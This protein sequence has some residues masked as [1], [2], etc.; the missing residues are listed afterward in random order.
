VFVPDNQSFADVFGTS[1][2]SVGGRPVETGQTFETKNLTV[3]SVGNSLFDWEFPDGYGIL[4]EDGRPAALG[5]AV[6]DI[7]VLSTPS[8]SV[9]GAEANPLVSMDSEALLTDETVRTLLRDVGISDADEVRWIEGPQRLSQEGYLAFDDEIAA[10]APE[11]FASPEPTIL[12]EATTIETYAGV[13]S[14][15]RGPWAVGVHVARATPDDHVSAIG[16]QRAPLEVSA[17]VTDEGRKGASRPFPIISWKNWYLDGRAMMAVV[18]PR[19]TEQG[20]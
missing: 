10:N 9:A 17:E 14:G 12:D 15:E 16:M 7:A 8:A 11:S 1:L 2:D 4:F 20:D 6:F 19:I 5:G 13:I 18:V 3:A